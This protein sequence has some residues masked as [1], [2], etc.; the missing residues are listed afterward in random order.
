MEGV[1]AVAAGQRRLLIR[2]QG[3]QE[4]ARRARAAI[5]GGLL[6]RNRYR[7]CIRFLRY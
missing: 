4:V 1:A 5:G 6:L 3:L 7:R 2:R